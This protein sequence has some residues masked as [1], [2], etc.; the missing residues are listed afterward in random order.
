[1]KSVIGHPARKNQF[2]E[3]KDLRDKI[4]EKIDTGSNVLLTAVRRAGKTSL[5]LNLIDEPPDEFYP[6]YIDSEHISNSEVFFQELHKEI[7]DTDAIES[8]GKFNHKTKQFFKEWSSKIS[9]IN[10]VGL[11]IKMDSGNENAYYD[12]FREFLK[13][14]KDDKKLVVIVDEFPITVDQIFKNKG[15]ESATHFLSLNRSLRQD[16]K[17]HDKIKFIYSGSI[18]LL[19]TV[20]KFNATDRIN[21]IEE[22]E[23]TPL[24]KYQAIEFV[25]SLLDYK[26]I[27]LREA[28]YL[29]E[30]LDWLNPFHIQLMGKEISDLLEADNRNGQMT[31][32]C[33]DKAF[34]KVV[35]NGNIYFEHYKSRLKKVYKNEAL[36]F[37]NELL[38]LIKEKDTAD[39][40]EIY[41]LAVKNK[42]TEEL[43][44]ILETLLYDG[45]L[46]CDKP[47]GKYTFYSPLLK[48]WWK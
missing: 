26:D 43:D 40:S 34:E 27:K 44:S 6:V 42:V 33:I 30:K 48:H 35:E 7:L 23:L 41:D 4:I 46:T 25:T 24:E 10:I 2:Y 18:G 20:R 32:A 37:I 15:K 21:D 45:Y 8:F 39:Y 19:S 38:L 12:K 47:K 5:L 1:M 29:I 11:D 31:K 3:R 16:P 36:V 28:D 13:A 22:M 17:L 9:K 14:Y